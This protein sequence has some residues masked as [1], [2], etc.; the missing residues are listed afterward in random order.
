MKAKQEIKQLDTSN[1]RRSQ[2]SEEI[3]SERD[4]IGKIRADLV[5]G[6]TEQRER[7]LKSGGRI[8]VDSFR[9]KFAQPVS[10]STKNKDI[11]ES[12]GHR[13]N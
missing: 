10:K 8:S 3:E 7:D 1:L 4:K 9:K 12:F 6:R 2:D 13:K 11:H 5:K